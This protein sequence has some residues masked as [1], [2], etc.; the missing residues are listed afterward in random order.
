MVATDNAP[1]LLALRL[2]GRRATIVGGGAVAARRIP[3]LLDSGA[4][5]V[6]VSPELSPPVAELAAGRQ[7]RWIRRGYA[8][9]DCARS[10]LVSACTSDPGVNPAVAQE[11]GGPGASRV[12]ADDRAASWA[13]SP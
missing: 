12:R 8:H 3:A 11:G 10:W 4:D 2:A 5:V 13:W 9:G 6:V 1:Y 7:I